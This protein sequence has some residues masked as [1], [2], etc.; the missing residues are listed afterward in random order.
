MAF[1]F[2]EFS[3][4]NSIKPAET[5]HSE[6]SEGIGDDAAVYLPKSGAEQLVS[7]DTMVEGIHFTEETMTAQDIGWKALAV[8]LSD[9]AAMGG[10]ADYYLVSI[11]LPERW[12][13]RVHDIYE[14]IQA[15]GRLYKA[16]LIGGDTVSSMHDLMISVTV[17]GHVPPGEKAYLR[18]DAIPGDHLLVTGTLGDSSAGLN[19]MLN[20]KD[21]RR[22]PFAESLI[23]AHQRPY[24]Q[25][26]AAKLLREIGGRFS[27]NDISDGISS[28][29]SEIAK[30]SNAGIEVW[31]DRL[32]VSE[33]LQAYSQGKSNL[34]WTLE[35]GEDY[36]LLITAPA[37]TL[38]SIT[39]IFSKSGLLITE[40][41]KVTEESGEVFLVDE[42][43][44]QPL[45]PRGFNHF[46]KNEG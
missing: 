10:V 16:D 27:V 18:S 12:K 6:L 13:E 28:E 23:K 38:G 26:T 37:G 31:Q 46:K 41:G 7:M 34:K 43:G 19:I 4:I 11:A 35:G 24:P 29:A 32:P 36:Q 20:E 3:F 22:Q 9:L 42:S 14:G 39:E 33:D 44:K 45:H 17:I 30:A 2:D 8:N 15:C 25:L 1:L 40:I 21:L 5:F